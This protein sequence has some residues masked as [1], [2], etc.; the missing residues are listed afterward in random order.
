MINKSDVEEILEKI[1]N[2][3]C[4]DKTMLYMGYICNNSV[5][6]KHFEGLELL[7]T[8][9]PSLNKEGSSEIRLL[10]IMKLM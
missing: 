4:D 7:K 6:S 3:S 10:A 9:L 1:K 2:P 5:Y 8:H